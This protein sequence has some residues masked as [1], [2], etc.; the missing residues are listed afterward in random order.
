MRPRITG[1]VFVAVRRLG[2]HRLRRRRVPRRTS[3]FRRRTASPPASPPAP[4]ARSGSRSS[5]PAASPG[6]TATGK[7]NEFPLPTERAGP[8]DITAGPD[9]NLWFTEFSADKIGRITPTG[10]IKEFPMPGERERPVRHHHRARRQP[11]VRHAEDATGS[12]A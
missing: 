9:G 3:A 10:E 8:F 11:L 2:G 6:S 1:I 12:P 5:P 7:I 4:T